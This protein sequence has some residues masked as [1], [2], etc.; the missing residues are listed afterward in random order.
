MVLNFLFKTLF[1][2]PLSEEKIPQTRREKKIKRGRKSAE[3]T[4]MQSAKK[5]PL[6]F[7]CKTLFEKSIKEEKTLQTTKQAPAQLT[8]GTRNKNQKGPKVGRAYT[9]AEFKKRIDRFPM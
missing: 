3:N 5:G 2:R 1:E 9:T 7:R 6:G 4:Q 8:R